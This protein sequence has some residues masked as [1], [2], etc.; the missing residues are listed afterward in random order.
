MIVNNPVKH[1]DKFFI[2]GRWVDPASDARIKVINSGTE[3]EFASVAE[4]TE[5][6]VNRAVSAARH[7]FD[8]GP[9]P[10]LSHKERATYIRA[11]AVEI[12]KLAESYALIWTVEA[13]VLHSM[14]SQRMPGLARYYNGFADLA[15]AYPFQERHV[16]RNGGQVA[17]LVREPVGVVAAIV[18]WNGAAGLMTNKVAPA[19]LTGCTVVVKSAPEAPCS[20]YLLAEAVERVGLPPG[21]V[22]I[23]TADRAVSEALVRHP[24]VDKVSFTGSTAAGRRIA[25]ICG[26][27][28]A[29]CT[30]ELG[31]KSPAIIMDDYDVEAAAKTIAA[32]AIVQTGQVCYSLTRIIV[33]RDRHDRLVEALSANFAKVKVGD[34]FDSA[35]EMGPLAMR[36]QRERVEN[37][38]AMGKAEGAKLATGGGRPRHLDR[39]FYVEPTV[40]GNVDNNST[41]GREEIFG[42]VLSVIPANDEA[43]AIDIAND[44]IFGLNSSVFT[45]DLERAYLTA[46]RLRTGT[47]GQNSLRAEQSIAIGGFKQ[48][49]I[50]REGGKEG[51]LPY[52]ETKVIVLDGMPEN[53]GPY[54]E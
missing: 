3:E 41:I 54:V 46:R 27:R 53:I 25:S 42:P 6:D 49:G 26:E 5:E 23:L 51:L 24:G 44:T 50:G 21:V 10:R 13:G 1:P 28:I 35:M 30:F 39:G 52:L 8:H 17:L 33:S 43:H 47:V 19:L 36:R 9:W 22:N 16:P 12:D 11:L 7:A 2:D 18:P 29:R 40:F 4:A 34:P 15:E 20:A 14:S 32:R 38:I 31:G 48:S 45:N 37:Y